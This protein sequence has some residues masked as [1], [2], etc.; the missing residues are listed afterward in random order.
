MSKVVKEAAGM[1]KPFASRGEVR[2]RS[3]SQPGASHVS[4]QAAQ[5]LAA[6]EPGNGIPCVG[7][8]ADHPNLLIAR[9][10]APPARAGGTA[11]QF[12][13]KLAIS[14]PGD[15]FEQEADRVAETVM[16]TP[17]PQPQG[18]SAVGGSSTGQGAAGDCDRSSEKPEEGVQRSS[19]SGGPST[20]APPIVNDVLRSPGEPL[21]AATRNYMEPRFG[22]EF[23]TVRVHTDTKAAESAG[24]IDSHAYTVGHDVV[25]AAGRYAPATHYG[26]KLLAHELTHVAQQTSAASRPAPENGPAKIATW[27]TERHT[28]SQ[29]DGASPA[30]YPV[31]G[32]Q[33]AAGNA[34]F[35]QMIARNLRQSDFSARPQVPM[36]HRQVDGQVLQRSYEQEGTPGKRPNIDSGDSGPGVALLQ[37]MLGAAQTGFF[38]P[39]TRKAVDRFQRQ[40]GWDPSGVGPM[41]WAAVD[42]HAGAPGRRPNL[43]EGDR[44]PGVKLLQQMLGVAETGFFG[45]TTRKAVDAFQKSQG[46]SPSGVGPMT[47]AALD[48]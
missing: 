34:N 17:C 2:A 37:R 18:T 39:Q 7:S 3:A 15:A 25:F 21:D 47:W 43:V 28:H 8:L 1:V 33:R 38:D 10:L 16:R 24:A 22:R 32:L 45:S 9:T 35:S 46:W 48:S 6:L 44:G 11:A 23:G 26:R 40:Q 19:S 27:R 29:H 4:N 12:Q 20:T 5:R 36:Q 42:D 41:T 30:P 31:L 14:Q 13:T